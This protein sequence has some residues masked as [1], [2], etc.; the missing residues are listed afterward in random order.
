M[1][2]ITKKVA[3]TGIGIQS[4][5]GSTIAE[6]THALRHGNTHF[7]KYEFPP[8][9]S[10]IIAAML[11]NEISISEKI[12]HLKHNQNETRKNY[13]VKLTN[14]LP[15]HLRSTISPVLEA[16]EQ[17]GMTQNELNT[18]R[19]GIVV[20]TQNSASHYQY[21]LRAGFDKQPEYLTPS[22]SLNY[23]DSA[24]VALISDIF[25]ITGE[26]FTVSASSASGNLA[27][28]RGLQLIR[29][30]Y[31]DICLIIGAAA[32]LSPM[33][34]QG[35]INIG[36]MGGQHFLD[37]PNEACRPFDKA[38]DGFIY[39]QASACMVL[40]SEESAQ[41]RN[42]SILGY[43]LGG[44]SVLDGNYF[45]DPWVSGEQRAMEKAIKDAGISQE[46]IEYINT[47]GTSASL[48]DK[49][50]LEAIEEVFG[51]HLKN[52][53]L[54][55]TKSITGHCLWSAGVV[56]AI[57]TVIQMQNGFLHPSLNILN[58]ISEKSQFVTGRSKSISIKKALSNS[59]GF[60]GINSSVIISKD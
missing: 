24:H 18:D 49:V 43:V 13:L 16:W 60:G 27:L 54:N 8:V 48:G 7:K 12:Y 52:I 44:A 59:F 46:Q 34:I 50:E 3:I 17:A 29:D 26:G 38:S 5:V 31:Q 53:F 39:G 33:D 6:F 32:D 51:T 20:A 2:Q 58:P 47:H 40:E 4:A 10:P 25:N 55:S 57:A 19:F 30:G 11:P 14:R 35:F 21:D 1:E 28:L 15:W 45:S 22:Y 37:K 56:E 41:Q 42:A 36:A 9:S 23:M